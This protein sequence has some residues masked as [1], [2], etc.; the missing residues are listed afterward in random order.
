MPFRSTFRIADLEPPNGFAARA[1]VSYQTVLQD[2]TR[3]GLTK[4]SLNSEPSVAT[5]LNLGDLE[6]R[7]RNVCFRRSRPVFQITDCIPA[8]IMR[9]VFDARLAKASRLLRGP[10]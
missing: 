3:N 1:G 8:M 7:W 10:D 4:G 5:T 6:W 2:A 9:S